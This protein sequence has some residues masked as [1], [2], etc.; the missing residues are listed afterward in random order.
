MYLPSDIARH[1]G[2]FLKYNDHEIVYTIHKRYTDNNNKYV[3][4]ESWR[5]SVSHG[6]SLLGFII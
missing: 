2:S 1:V 5:K 4:A 6:L 3:I